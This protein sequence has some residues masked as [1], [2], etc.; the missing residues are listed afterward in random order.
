MSSI[1]PPCH[2]SIPFP[3]I[4]SHLASFHPFP[5]HTSIRQP[6]HHST[7]F[8]PAFHSSLLPRPAFLSPFAS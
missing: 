8:P 2:N 1:H 4:H 5:V 3:P 7:S 6:V